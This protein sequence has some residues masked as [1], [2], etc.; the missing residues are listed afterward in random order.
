MREQEHRHRSLGEQ[1]G[2][3]GVKTAFSEGLGTP[4]TCSSVP[5]WTLV[6]SMHRVD[7]QSLSCCWT[8]SYTVSYVTT[9]RQ[10]HGWGSAAPFGF[11][12][13]WLVQWALFSL[14]HHPIFPPHPAAICLFVYLLTLRPICYVAQTSLKFKAVTMPQPSKCR[15]L[16]LALTGMWDN[17]MH[18][19]H[20]TL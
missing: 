13:L 17:C 6:F 1:L 5:A 4:R 8:L 16:F 15:D 18:V 19:Q 9:E 10:A 2:G 20:F 3:S 12:S 7:R 14:P 11:H